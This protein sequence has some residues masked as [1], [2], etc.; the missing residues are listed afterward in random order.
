MHR[1]Y[2]TDENT[3]KGDARF[4]CGMSSG[5]SNMKQGVN[6]MARG[7]SDMT[8]SVSDSGVMWST[9]L[10]LED[11]FRTVTGFVSVTIITAT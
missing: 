7:M 8:R 2:L 9:L 3:D 5:V 1:K 4:A 6:D 10:Q 11:V